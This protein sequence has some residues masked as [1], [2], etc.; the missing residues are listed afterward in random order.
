M[1]ICPRHNLRYFADVIVRHLLMEQVAHGVDEDHSRAPPGQWF[2]QLAGNEPWIKTTLISMANNST[3]SLGEPLG[4]T[5]LAPWADFCTAA[6]RVPG[7]IGPFDL[8]LITHASFD[9]EQSIYTA[10]QLLYPVKLRASHLSLCI[11]GY[12]S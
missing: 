11:S 4:I 6:D 7:C 9:G 8:G 12:S 3:E 5:E 1:P 10:P 2:H